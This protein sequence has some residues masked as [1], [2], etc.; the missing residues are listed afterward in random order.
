MQIQ[1]LEKQ[2]KESVP[3]LVLI[4]GE[5]KAIVNRAVAMLKALIPEDQ[6]A[7]NFASYDLKTTPV[8]VALDDAMSP[9][10]FGDYREVVLT[11][12]VMFTGESAPTK[13]DHDVDSLLQYLNQ[14]VPSTIMVVVAPYAKLD[15]RKR[16]SKALKKNALLIDATTLNEN[17][18]MQQIKADLAQAKI[19]IEPNALQLLAQRTNGNYSLMATELPKLMAFAKDQAVL[20]AANIEQ[21]VPKQ[22][23]DRVFDLVGAVLAKNATAALGLYRELLAQNEEPIKL[24][25]LLLSQFRL[26]IQ[27]QI[28]MK[29]GY[30]QGSLAQTLKVHPYRI[31]L[32]WQ[33]SQRL[34]P[35]DLHRAFIGL[36]D[37]DAQMKRGQVDKT[38]A[39]ELFVLQY[40]GQKQAQ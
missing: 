12:P 7:M 17:K 4:L 10:F 8:A 28:L 36:V 33:Q 15:D 35:D 30:S 25:S 26:L 23:S 19:Q 34:N 16:L 1:E 3:P 13:I 27:V 9:P 29:K 37:L 20:T 32:A 31:K 38:L 6:K 2:L 14:P 11:E 40:S 22:L 21:L 18:A 5:E 39:F 24:I